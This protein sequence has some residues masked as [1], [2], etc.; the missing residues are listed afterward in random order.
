MRR[1][2]AGERQHKGSIL[3]PLYA[4]SVISRNNRK[5]P[6]IILLILKPIM[7]RRIIKDRNVIKKPHV[8][9]LP[10]ISQY[11]KLISHDDDTKIFADF[12]VRHTT[13]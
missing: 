10:A 8:D 13:C 6:P 4:H 11:L 7:Q 9:F 2:S 12:P 5:I 3:L 1:A